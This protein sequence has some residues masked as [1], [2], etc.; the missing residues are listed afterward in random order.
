MFC[1]L[2]VSISFDVLACTSLCARVHLVSLSI[3]SFFSFF[4]ING[5]VIAPQEA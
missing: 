3:S 2:N 5:R 4:F 1:F